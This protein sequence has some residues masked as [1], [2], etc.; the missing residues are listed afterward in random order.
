[1][2]GVAASWWSAAGVVAKVIESCG[3]RMGAED[4]CYGVDR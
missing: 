2:G 4:F 1:M 3:V